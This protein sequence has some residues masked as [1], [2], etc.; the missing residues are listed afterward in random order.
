MTKSER[1]NIYYYIELISAILFSILSVSFHAD[2]SLLAFPI[3]AIFTGITVYFGFFKFLKV[4]NA[5]NYMLN[6]KLIQYLPF[7]LFISFIFRRAGNFATST[8]Y[9][10]ITVILWIVNFV[11]SFFISYFLNEKKHKFIF[12]KSWINR[13]EKKI[14]TP[15]VAFA[16]WILEWIDALVQAVFMVLLLQIFV[17]QLYLIPSESMVPNL[18]VGDR[19]V[20]SKINCGPKFPLTEIGLPDLGNYK[21]GDIVVLRNP[22]YKM[23]R[24]SDVKTVVAQ[25]VHMITFTKVNIDKD[26]NGKQKYDPLVKRIAGEEGEQIVMQ[27]GILYAR[28]KDK[29]DFEPVPLDNKYAAWNLNELSDNTKKYINTIPLQQSYYDLLLDIEE[30]RRN[31]DLNKAESEING[32]IVKL[33]KYTSNKVDFQKTDLFFGQFYNIIT[34]SDL[35]SIDS[36]FKNQEGFKWF[37][38]YLTSWL[39]NKDVQKDIY[40]EAN[41]KLNVMFKYELSNYVT[42]YAELEAQNKLDSFFNDEIVIEAERNIENI[43]FYLNI[44]DQRNMPVFPACTEDGEPVYIPKNCYFMMGDNRFNS[45]D[46]RHSYDP[47][48]TPLS[49]YD[50]MSITYYSNIEPQYINK[51]LIIGKPFYRIFPF[52]RTGKLNQ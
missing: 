7:V 3:A 21:R 10:V 26:E 13:P 33:S 52:S 6:L 11:V 8:F 25:I 51:K 41:Y 2:I 30:S 42:R 49:K 19:V 39:P 15:V 24:K 16:I 20:V 32:N 12:D 44:L 47:Q 37:K 27:D 45:L 34:R 1:F 40:Q 36:L 14:H 23:D 18:L 31:F 43:S 46:L 48:F 5:K 17:A 22:H 35:A 28:T 50:S 9:D 29:P 4:K 38:E